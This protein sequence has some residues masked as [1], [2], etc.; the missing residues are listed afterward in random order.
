MGVAGRD[1]EAT[2]LARVGLNIVPQTTPHKRHFFSSSLPSSASTPSKPA[3]QLLPI[4]PAHNTPVAKTPRAIGDEVMPVADDASGAGGSWGGADGEPGGDSDRSDGARASGRE[5][6]CCSPTTSAPGSPSPKAP[7]QMQ[8]ADQDDDMLAQ[9]RPQYT[10]GPKPLHM[11]S[12]L[13]SSPPHTQHLRAVFE[14]LCVDGSK[15]VLFVRACAPTSGQASRGGRRGWLRASSGVQGLAATGGA[16][17]RRP[18]DNT[19]CSSNPQSGWSRGM[20]IPLAQA[21]PAPLF[22]CRP[23]A[24]TRRSR[25]WRCAPQPTG[26]PRS[27]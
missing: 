20:S 7:Y 9:V 25:A 13:T 18:N 15:E 8:F 16:G 3:A 21:L 6:A 27:C 17:E 26:F 12:A 14:E 24:W 10:A 22:G 4:S 11:S 1:D 19:H 2:S 5:Q 23:A